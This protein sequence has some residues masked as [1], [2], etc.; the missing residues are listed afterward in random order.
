MESGQAPKAQ[1]IVQAHTPPSCPRCAVLDYGTLGGPW[2]A[3]GDVA[4]PW[5]SRVV[6]V[7]DSRNAMWGTDGTFAN[8]GTFDEDGLIGSTITAADA[9]YIGRQIRTWK[10]V[11]SY[12]YYLAVVLEGD[13]MVG[14]LPEGYETLADDA[15]TFGDEHQEVFIRL[16]HTA[17]EGVL[18]GLS[19]DGTFGDD[20]VFDA[21][22]EFAV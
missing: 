13:G 3:G 12:P 4:H 11:A 15:G 1:P 18:W 8:E 5:W 20:G 7:I 16:G 17:N 2:W 9:R 22:I 14:F 19:P 21:F 10:A 6:I